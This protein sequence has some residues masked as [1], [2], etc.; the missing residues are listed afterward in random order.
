MNKRTC[1]I[2]GCDGPVS[3]RGWCSKH[4][5]RWQ[6]NGDPLVNRRPLQEP[7]CVAVGCDRRSFQ[8]SRCLRHYRDWQRGQRG[9]CLLGDCDEPWQA[10]GLC[11]KHYL[12]KH[13]TGS[14][15]DPEAAGRPCSVSGCEAR[16]R[17]RE[18]CQGHY[19]NWRKYGTAIAPIKPARV[20][21][22][23]IQDNCEQP[24]R[25]RNGMCDRHYRADR[26]ARKP[27]CSIPECASPAC[28][29]DFCAQHCGWSRYLYV[30]YGITPERYDALVREQAGL[31]AI[32]R[33]PPEQGRVKRLVV[34]H[35]HRC[36]PANRSCG[37]CVRGLL[38]NWCNRLL[39]MATDDPERL[40]S[41]ILY[42]ERNACQSSGA[43]SGGSGVTA[44]GR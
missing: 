18:L 43:P 36:C 39:G 22:P 15:D 35:D 26:A 23:C 27:K 21:G 30:T 25:R 13:R 32:C 2:N 8:R 37:E 44:P 38:C 14:T 7:T 9:P 16:A 3:G 40:R 4:Y 33:R 17:A 20:I 29:G 1:S 12:R 31:C 5:Q 19:K 28:R 10:S 11:A 41:A 24:G 34:D 6:S 42:L